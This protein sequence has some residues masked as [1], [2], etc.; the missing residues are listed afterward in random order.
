MLVS[1]YGII[2]D[3]FVLLEY[4]EVNLSEHDSRLP[5]FPW[6][7]VKKPSWVWSCMLSDMIFMRFHPVGYGINLP[8]SAVQISS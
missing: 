4:I 3:S 7:D 2:G 6:S 5:A 8:G 1:S